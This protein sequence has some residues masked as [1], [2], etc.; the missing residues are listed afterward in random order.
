MMIAL[1][2]ANSRVVLGK[3]LGPNILLV[4]TTWTAIESSLVG[5]FKQNEKIRVKLIQFPQGFGVKKS[6]NYLKFHQSPD[7]VAASLLGTWNHPIHRKINGTLVSCMWAMKRYSGFFG[8]RETWVRPLVISWVSGIHF[9]TLRGLDES[10]ISP[11]ESS[12]HVPCIRGSQV[13]TG[14]WKPSRSCDNLE[15]QWVGC[16]GF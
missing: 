16:F 4:Q 11:P 13:R 3:K 2:P 10:T 14:I 15:V 6:K 8:V 9:P 7:L 12:C 5:G 1:L